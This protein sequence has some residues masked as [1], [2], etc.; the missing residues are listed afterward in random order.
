MHKAVGS[1]DSSAGDAPH[2]QPEEEEDDIDTIFDTK[3]L[4]SFIEDVDSDGL[5]D[6]RDL[7]IAGERARSR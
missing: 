7:E 1:N 2:L 6:A 3:E 5:I 4:T